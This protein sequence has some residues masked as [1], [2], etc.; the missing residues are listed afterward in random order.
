MREPVA[1]HARGSCARGWSRVGNDSVGLGNGR[2]VETKAVDVV[3]T[4]REDGVAPFVVRHTVH[5]IAADGKWSWIVPAWR[6]GYFRDNVCPS[7]AHTPSVPA[8]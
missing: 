3:V 8:T 6:Y 5:V 1:I 4:L 2:F 7:P